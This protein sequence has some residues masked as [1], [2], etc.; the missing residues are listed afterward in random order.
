MR[1][2]FFGAI[3]QV[4]FLVTTK[5]PTKPHMHKKFHKAA[6]NVYTKYVVE[7]VRKKTQH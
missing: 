2:N 5:K 6:K 1:V 4:K 3:F 7:L